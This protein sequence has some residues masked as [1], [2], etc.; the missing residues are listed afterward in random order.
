MKNLK[1]I[2][3]ILF[4][5]TAFCQ[6]ANAQEKLVFLSEK[7]YKS[8]IISQED[9]TKVEGVLVDLQDSTITFKDLHVNVARSVSIEDIHGFEFRKIRKGNGGLWGGIIGGVSGFVLGTLIGGANASSDTLAEA[10]VR[11]I[12]ILG[13]GILG[14]IG[15]IVIGAN[16][17]S[18][19][20]AKVT[21]PI[22]GNKQV[23]EQQKEKLKLYSLAPN[24]L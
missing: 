6:L 17:G 21:I 20:G 8:W 3:T 12:A 24:G 23:Y 19:N 14:G 13:T 1:S 22:F 11:P 16:I 9:I 5:T 7:E 2:F 4:I 15:G 10:F 18:S